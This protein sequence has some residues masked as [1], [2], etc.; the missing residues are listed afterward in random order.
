[1]LTAAS[2]LAQGPQAEQDLDQNRPICLKESRSS[3]ELEVA[4]GLQCR[5]ML[6]I[7]S[8]IT[9]ST[10]RESRSDVQLVQT[11]VALLGPTS[12][13][14]FLALSRPQ[15]PAAPMKKLQIS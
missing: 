1:M 15:V 12:D 13:L 5:H 6:R 9:L 2:L 3:A 4:G 8:K 10:K 7:I 11:G 14:C